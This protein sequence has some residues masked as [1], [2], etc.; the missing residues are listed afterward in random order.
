MPYGTASRG[1]AA[2]CAILLLQRRGNE[3]YAIFKRSVEVN[4]RDSLAFNNLVRHGTADAL[5]LPL[6]CTALR[7]TAQRRLTAAP[8]TADGC[9]VHATSH[10]GSA[11]PAM[12]QGH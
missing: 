2:R 8:N 9:A 7:C 11:R 10:D 5:Q 1:G 12:A 3:A 6:R 4:P